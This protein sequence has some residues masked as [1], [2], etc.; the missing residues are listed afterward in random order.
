[1]TRSM[2]IPLAAAVVALAVAVP[3][4]P[5]AH[6]ADR[7]LREFVM[8]PGRDDGDPVPKAAPRARIQSALPGADAA[9]D[10]PFALAC[11]AE[12][13]AMADPLKAPRG[14]A[15]PRCPGEPFT[16]LAERP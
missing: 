4:L 8:P 5:A 10:Q 11:T 14:A 7:P 3:A 12:E 16:V 13:A 6:A 15:A 9:G 2:T 1:M